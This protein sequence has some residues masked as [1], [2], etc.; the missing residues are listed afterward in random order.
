[1][2]NLGIRRQGKFL[3]FVFG[4]EESTKT[5]TTYFHDRNIS[6]DNW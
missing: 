6:L 1:M 3:F 5:Y 4:L 2:S